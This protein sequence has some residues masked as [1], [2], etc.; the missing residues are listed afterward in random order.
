MK[1]LI[2]LIDLIKDLGRKSL[3]DVGL[4]SKSLCFTQILDINTISPESYLEECK[5]T[6]GTFLHKLALHP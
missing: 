6:G 1:G 3:F 4:K 2:S 5:F